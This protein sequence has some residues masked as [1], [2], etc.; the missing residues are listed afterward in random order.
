MATPARGEA[1]RFIRCG[2][3]EEMFV[4]KINVMDGQPM[5]FPP[6]RKRGQCQ[7]PLTA[8][9]WWDGEA[10]SGTNVGEDGAGVSG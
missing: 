1:T 10:W 8:S 4:P 2:D 3:C 6:K 7:H 5:W 9:E